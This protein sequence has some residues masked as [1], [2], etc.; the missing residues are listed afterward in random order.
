MTMTIPSHR[1]SIAPMMDWTD[2]HCRYFLRLISKHALLYTEM[3]T[4][5]A[6]IY[7]DRDRHLAFDEREHPVALQLGGSN[8]TELATCSKVGE[9]YGYDEINLNVGCPSDRVQNGR[10]GACL[11]AEPQLVADCIAAMQANVKIPVTVKTRIGIDDLDSYEHLIHFIETV[12][13][14]GCKTFIIHARKAWLQGLSP[15]ENRTIPP[16]HYDRAYQLKQDFPHLNII[17]NG[18]IK[19]LDA[20]QEHLNY[21]D[22]VM[23]G[24]EAY[25]NP[26]LLADVDSLIFND[27]KPKLT[28]LEII[29]A[30]IPYLQNN[31]DKGLPLTRMSRH[32]LGLFHNAPGGR[33]W[34]RYL[35]EHAHQENNVQV[36]RD[37][38]LKTINP[39]LMCRRLDIQ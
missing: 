29:E 16:I 35:S 15:R 5:G 20:A 32:I 9:D 8:P 11:M 1:F 19:T 10:F 28:R 30:F 24:R 22:G 39:S 23:L 33:L 6:I 12:S 17:V 26:Y 18:E 13:A 4:T 7:G 25:Q 14:A 36:I 3:V 27:P 31:L 34:R 37:A 2:R 38:L 21:V